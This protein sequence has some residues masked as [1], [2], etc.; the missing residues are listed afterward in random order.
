[1]K[2]Q[3][4]WIAVILIIY[5]LI[6]SGCI[7]KET[8]SN[9]MG[10]PIVRRAEP[11]LNEII[12]EDMTLRAQSSSIVSECPSGDRECQ[13]N[14]LYRFVIDDFSYYSDPRKEEFIQTP[15]IWCSHLTMH[16]VWHVMLTQNIYWNISGNPF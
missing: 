8:L 16:T 6:I 14:K 5:T 13:I 4:T 9:L 11:Y 1:M 10:D 15:F 2:K 12:F 3:N 7:E